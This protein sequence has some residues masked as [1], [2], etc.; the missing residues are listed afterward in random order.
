MTKVWIRP[1]IRPRRISSPSARIFPLLRPSPPYN[2]LQGVPMLLELARAF[3]FFLSI[4][5]LYWM[6]ISAFFVPGSRFEDR[7][8]LALLRLAFA[9][10]VCFLSGI[11]FSWPSRT[12]RRHPHL[13]STLPVQLFFWTLAAVAILFIG[14]WYLS[15]WPCS[16]NST[17]DCSL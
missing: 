14:S 5:S 9:A 16:I 2:L 1:R 17:A 7:L 4:L 13:V 8:M 6:A 11:L 3:S 15:S 12:R 10:C